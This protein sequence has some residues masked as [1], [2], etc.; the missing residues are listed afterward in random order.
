[1]TLKGDTQIQFGLR[2]ANPALDDVMASFDKIDGGASY[3]T[4]FKPDVEIKVKNHIQGIARL[5]RRESPPWFVLSKSDEHAAKLAGV[6]LVRYAESASTGEALKRQGPAG[7][8]GTGATAHFWAR[9][10]SRHPGGLQQCGSIV[11]VAQDPK[12]GVSFVSLFDLHDPDHAS[13]LNTLT[14]DGTHHTGNP[15]DERIAQGLTCVGLTR[16]HD[17]TSLLFAYRY[18]DSQP[19]LCYGQLFRSSTPVN[20]NATWTWVSTLTLGKGLPQADWEPKIEN[21][22]LI[23]QTDGAIF[24]VALHGNGIFNHAALYHLDANGSALTHRANKR[25]QTWAGGATFRAGGTTYITP[26]RELLIY[27]TEKAVPDQNGN[28]MIEEFTP[29]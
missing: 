9:D 12:I 3:P 19:E 23:N 11:A 20:A 16:L 7:G 27:A 10:L 22:A 29:K 18:S 13:R 4:L 14:L 8:N 28:M 26:S 6:L 1:V 25:V 24:L 17:G 2:D 5:P 15:H 21:V